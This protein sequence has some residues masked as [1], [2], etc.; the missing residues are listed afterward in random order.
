MPI[1]WNESFI[2][3]IFKKGN[4]FDPNNYRGITIIKTLH[5]ILCKFLVNRINL[6]NID[7]TNIKS[8][9]WLY[10]KRRMCCPSGH[11]T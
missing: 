11:T 10:P 1:E 8:T 9:E 2:V 3:P 6:L 7:N 4:A 5:K